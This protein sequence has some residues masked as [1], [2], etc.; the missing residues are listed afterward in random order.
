ME[1]F[2]RTDFSRLLPLVYV[3]I[4]SCLVIFK[5]ATEAKPHL[6]YIFLT[7]VTKSLN[8]SNKS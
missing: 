5:C 6:S 8:H 7:L 3:S 2:T 4:L 1:M